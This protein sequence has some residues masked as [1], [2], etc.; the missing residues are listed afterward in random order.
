MP[1]SVHAARWITQLKGKGWDIHLFPAYNA[2]PHPTL[3][4]IKFHDSLADAIGRAVSL[5]IQWPLHRRGFTRI[6]RISD[7]LASSFS[8]DRS[9]RLAKVIR[10]IKP[11]VIHSLE[12]QQAGYLTLDARTHFSSGFPRWI[13][14]N[15]GNDIYQLMQLFLNLL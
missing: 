15:Y 5:K 2:R 14:Q 6:Q 3:G 12:I 13:V 10:E 9:R 8:R 1:D 4:N 7:W 11:D